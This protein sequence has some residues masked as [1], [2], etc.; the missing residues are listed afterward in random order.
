MRK[1]LKITEELHKKIKV[2]C[3]TNDIK[4]NEWVE[5]ELLKLLQ[6][7]DTNQGG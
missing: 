3:V 2:F 1:T 5:I 7:Y 6:I 4:M